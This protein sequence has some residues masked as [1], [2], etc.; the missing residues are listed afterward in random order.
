MSGKE[1]GMDC[2]PVPV[3]LIACGLPDPLSAIERVAVRLPAAFGEKPIATWQLLF[4]GR[5][6]PLQPSD[7]TEKSPAFVPEIPTD[8]F[9]RVAFPLFVKVAAAVLLLG[10][11]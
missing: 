10:I 5:I 7:E 6:T 3:K 4:A 9:V 8:I 2:T 1:V 11:D